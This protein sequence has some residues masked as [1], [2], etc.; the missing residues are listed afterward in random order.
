MR[1]NVAQGITETQHCGNGQNESGTER[2][3]GSWE[4]H[5]ITDT[6]HNGKRRQRGQNRAQVL[7]NKLQTFT[8]TPTHTHRQK[9]NGDIVGNREIE[10]DKWTSVE[11]SVP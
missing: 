2:G 11:L 1:S 4:C 5:L 7:S 8:I 3:S 6:K 9:H 10:S